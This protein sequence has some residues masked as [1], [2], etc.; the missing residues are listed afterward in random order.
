MTSRR[1][2]LLFVGGG[3]ATYG[4]YLLAQN[5]T[6]LR[7]VGLLT[8]SSMPAFSH[9]FES[10]KLGMQ[11]FGWIE[12]RNVEYRVATADGRLERLDALA[13]ELVAQK[14]EVLVGATAPIRAL[15]KAT[16]RVPIVMA[17]SVQAVELGYVASLAKP[18]ENI[19]GISSE[20][21]L[22]IP[23]L[24]QFLREALPRAKR[25]GV[26]VDELE[27]AYSVYWRSAEKACFALGL[28]PIRLGIK[29]PQ[30]MSAIFAQAVNARSD[31]VIIPPGSMFFS[32]RAA[33]E[34]LL[35]QH[36]LPAGSAFREFAVAG[37]LLSY[38]TNVANNF[39]HAAKFVDRILKGALPADLP[40]EQPVKYDM[41]VNLKTA[42]AL[43]IS[44]P[45]GLL[46]RA[47]EVIE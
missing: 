12:G 35:L 5:P 47:D 30:Q 18:G 13:A 11:E 32:E 22:L 3:L 4:Q 23:K 33:I 9:L 34:K 27:P 8:G 6:I 14:F 46:L 15:Q 25:I 38:G 43:R 26:L 37:G 42:K 44:V 20:Y 1:Q 24:V 2:L 21:E 16:S 10:F 17:S 40:V 39:R 19:T 36:R 31:A 45:Q 28:E 7:R 29:S 41:V